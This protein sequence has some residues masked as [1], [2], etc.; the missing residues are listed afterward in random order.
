[1]KLL[2]DSPG[3]TIREIREAIWLSEEKLASILRFFVDFDVEVEVNNHGGRHYV[4]P[5]RPVNS[6]E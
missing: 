5:I 3:H 2:Q 4:A 6:S 1:L